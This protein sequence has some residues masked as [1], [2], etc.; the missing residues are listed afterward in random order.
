[1]QSTS[2]IRRI[3]AYG[4]SNKRKAFWASVCSVLNK[5]FDIA[6]EILIGVAL[7][8]VIRRDDSF[9]SALG[10]TQVEHQLI[11]LGVL[12]LLIWAF[13][14]LFQYLYLM[15]WRNLAQ[16]VQHSFR[17][18]SYAH[19]QDMDIA[20]FENQPTGRLTAILNDDINQLERFLNV[21]ANDFLQV[22]TS[23]LA[24]GCVFFFLS[25][26]IALFAFTPIPIIIFG[27]FYF[28]RKAEP[29]YAKV[30]S[31][32]GK[33]AGAINNNI[34]GIATIKSFTREPEEADN[35]NQLS[36]D[37][38][39]ANTHAIA[40][41]SA[42]IPLIRMA[43]LSGSETMDLY[44]RGMASARRIFNLL[45]EPIQ[46]RDHKNAQHVDLDGSIKLDNVNF[47]YA[48]SPR[49]VLKSL[50]LQIEKNTTHAFVGHYNHYDH[51]LV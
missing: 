3:L 35:I 45:D 16:D 38:S 30:R 46:I 6:P 39:V 51:K 11:A 40:I 14:S 22:I 49:L 10:I 44:E 8:V 15:L 47:S 24:V 17:K 1:M 4:K 9:V 36:M 18:D 12:T 5:L 41:S 31:L 50:D 33:L 19:I 25:P 13:E 37:Y 29:R 23:V 26:K 32:A 28:Q 7:D 27:A 48:S 34:A 2:P 21:G 43:I 20:F 42:F